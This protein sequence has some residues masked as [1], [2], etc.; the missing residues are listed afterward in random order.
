MLPDRPLV[1]EDAFQSRIANP[2]EKP[3]DV[4]VLVCQFQP[5]AGELVDTRR[6]RAAQLA[7]A[8]GTKI[9]VPD[10]VSEDEHDIGLA[11]LRL[12]RARGPCESAN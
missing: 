1:L 7:A 11:G 9:A 6:R 5:V 4:E 2:T 10:V 12:R 8:V 3:R